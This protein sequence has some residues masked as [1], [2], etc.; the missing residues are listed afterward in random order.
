MPGRIKGDK[1]KTDNMVRLLRVSTYAAGTPLTSARA[2]ARVA[3]TALAPMPVNSR[4]WWKRFWYQRSVN[5]LGGTSKM[6][7]GLN[8]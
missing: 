2:V 1:K 6:T 3:I 5:A 7:V 8:E 4:S